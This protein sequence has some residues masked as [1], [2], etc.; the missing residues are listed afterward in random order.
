MTGGV[1]TTIVNGRVLMRDGV[2]PGEE[3]ILEEAQK[4]FQDL[5]NR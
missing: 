5:V 4:R 3:K 1:D 2:I